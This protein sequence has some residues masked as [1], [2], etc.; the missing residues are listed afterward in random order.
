MMYRKLLFVIVMI[1]SVLTT[2]AQLD[3]GE[4]K[5]IG[6]INSDQFCLL[7]NLEKR[8]P[9]HYLNERSVVVNKELLDKH[10]ELNDSIIINLLREGK[11]F[12]YYEDCYKILYDVSVLFSGDDSTLKLIQKSHPIRFFEDRDGC[13]FSIIDEVMDYIIHQPVIVNKKYY[14]Q[15]ISTKC[16]LLISAP[17]RICFKKLPCLSYGDGIYR[18]FW[19][20][21]ESSQEV[22]VIIP[23]ICNG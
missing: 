9:D 14:Y 6:F 19:L 15:K 4:I 8:S 21:P 16:F 22:M 2:Y 5:I 12:L 20:H 7:T 17:Y 10:E 23:L 13:L 18:D 11:A 3:T 1:A